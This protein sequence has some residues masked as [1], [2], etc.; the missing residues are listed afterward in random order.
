MKDDMDVF[1]KLKIELPYD[2]EI[3]ILGIYLGK[4]K[5]GW[6]KYMQPCIHC[7][8]VYNNQGIEAT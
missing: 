6:K 4:K 2:P 7:S 8:A 5:H 1:K 3:P